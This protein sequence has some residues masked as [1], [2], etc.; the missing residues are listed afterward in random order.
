VWSLGV[1]ERARPPHPLFRRQNGKKIW[2]LLLPTLPHPR[3]PPP[4]TPPA[5]FSMGGRDTL[6]ASRITRQPQ[7]A[8]CRPRLFSIGFRDGT[9]TADRIHFPQSTA[10]PHHPALPDL[11]QTTPVRRRL[12]AWASA[13]P[14]PRGGQVSAMPAPGQRTWS[15][16]P[17]RWR[18][19]AHVRLVARKVARRRRT[20]TAETETHRQPTQMRARKAWSLRLT[21]ELACVTVRG[22]AGGRARACCVRALCMG[23]R[24]RPCERPCWRRCEGVFV[25]GCVSAGARVRAGRGVEAE[26]DRRSSADSRHHRR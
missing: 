17:S 9:C 20:V 15:G 5:R 1:G 10:H 6:P 2:R 16:M 24:A 18:T 23:V 4:P 22:W 12:H 7:P 14:P 21:M 3:L 19:A 25:C 26:G 13:C 11:P 8:Q